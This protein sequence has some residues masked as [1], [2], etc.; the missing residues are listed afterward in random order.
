MKN[1]G[2]ANDAGAIQL[3][4]R[5]LASRPGSATTTRGMRVLTELIQQIAGVGALGA[6]ARSLEGAVGNVA[7]IDHPWCSVRL[8]QANLL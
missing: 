1:P 7:M 5:E 6:A 8:A 3:P 2:I 4:V